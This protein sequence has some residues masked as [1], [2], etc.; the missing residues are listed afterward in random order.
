MYQT[1]ELLHTRTKQR[2]MEIVTQMRASRKNTTNAILLIATVFRE[3]LWDSVDFRT[4]NGSPPR[5]ETGLDWL[6][7]Q[8]CSE[9]VLRDSIALIWRDPLLGEYGPAEAKFWP[10]LAGK[11]P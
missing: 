6:I 11:G 9:V 8:V 7:L 2:D 4:E 3:R 10:W 1:F 5:P